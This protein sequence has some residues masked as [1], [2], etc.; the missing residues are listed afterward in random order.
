MRVCVCMCY[1][2]P[3]WCTPEC[4]RKAVGERRRDFTGLFEQEGEE[5]LT[6]NREEKLQFVL[7]LV[8]SPQAVIHLKE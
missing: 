7:R 3:V 5:K 8:L 6:K 4:V 1:L 2:Q